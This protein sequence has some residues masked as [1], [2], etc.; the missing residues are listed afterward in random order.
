MTTKLTTQEQIVS[1]LL[2]YDAEKRQGLN[3]LAGNGTA[4]EQATKQIELLINEAEKRGYEKANQEML[5]EIGITL[6]K[7]TDVL[8][9][10]NGKSKEVK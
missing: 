9:I 4:L 10:A 3:E 6:Q 7:A 8:K 1:I 5:N 2:Q